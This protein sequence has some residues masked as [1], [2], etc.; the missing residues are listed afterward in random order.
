MAFGSDFRGDSPT[1]KFT[2]WKNNPILTQRQLDAE[3]PNPVTC[4][5]HATWFKP[6]KGIGGQSFWLAVP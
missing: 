5:G 3:R 4:A 1:G 2:P 6:G